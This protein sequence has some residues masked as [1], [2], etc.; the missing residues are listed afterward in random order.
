MHWPYYMFYTDQGNSSSLS[1]DHTSWKVGHSPSE[2]SFGPSG[3]LHTK[4]PLR[5]GSP[6]ASK[7]PQFFPGQTC[8]LLQPC[9]GSVAGGQEL[10]QGVGGDNILVQ[11][12]LARKKDS[13]PLLRKEPLSGLVLFL[14]SIYQSS[15]LSPTVLLPLVSI[16]SSESKF[17]IWV[18]FDS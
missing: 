16:S 11:D 18:N 13:S 1:V 5:G 7:A 3:K 2:A 8:L 10:Q 6:R 4:N 15:A 17:W 14:P 9:L 12:T